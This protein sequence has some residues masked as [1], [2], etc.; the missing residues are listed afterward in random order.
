MLIM[1]K[2]AACLIFLCMAF[3]GCVNIYVRFPTTDA[4]I[5]KTY[6]ST[7]EAALLSTVLMF[8]QIMNDAP[9]K[10]LVWENV[11][12]IPLGCVGFCDTACEAVL[13]TVL[14]L[15]DYTLAAKRNN[16]T[17]K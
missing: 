4:R 6:Q 9:F 3:C 13:D 8:P 5:E 12:T 17:G 10:G 2:L 14:F 16:K 11:Y 1:R 7:E 15:P